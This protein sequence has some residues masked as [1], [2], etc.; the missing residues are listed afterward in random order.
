MTDKDKIIA[1]LRKQLKD[2]ASRCNALEQ[3]NAL[4][5]YQLEKKGVKCPASR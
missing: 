2:A 5:V 1:T 4:L 3:E